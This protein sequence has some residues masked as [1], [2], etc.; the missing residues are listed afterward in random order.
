[1]IRESPFRIALS[2]LVG[3]NNDGIPGRCPGLT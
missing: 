1:P 3:D 2:G